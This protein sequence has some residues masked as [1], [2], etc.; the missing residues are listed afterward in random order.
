MRINAV[1][2]FQRKPYMP[3]TASAAPD[4]TR[5]PNFGSCAREIYKN[6]KT[7]EFAAFEPGVRI[8]RDNKFLYSNYTYFMRDDVP[9][10]HTGW[11]GFIK[12]IDREFQNA[13]KVNV[14][15]F[16]CSDGSEAYSL[17]LTLIE[18]LGEEKAQKF[19]PIKASD[20]D[21]GILDMARNG[22][23]C[24]TSKD[25]HVL[26][27]CTKYNLSKYFDISDAP[28]IVGT[29]PRY[30]LRPKDILKNA[31]T[32]EKKVFPDA[33]NEIEPENSLVLCRN[34]W[35]YMSDSGRSAAIDKLKSKLGE[36]S[37]FVIG[38]FDYNNFETIFSD[39]DFKEI[40]FN[41]YK[42]NKNLSA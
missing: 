11:E 32:F 38:D 19:F 33:L 12:L 13:D 39:K 20:I 4:C 9:F 1:N 5:V 30:T 34:F 42:V 21:E 24:C 2:T 41:F 36:S 10:R 35:P 22:E 17:A 23:I 26:D 18:T 25:K 40:H 15:D 8:S 16:G 28:P 27:R 31:V 6:H 7:G 14:Y 29:L 3:K 37:R